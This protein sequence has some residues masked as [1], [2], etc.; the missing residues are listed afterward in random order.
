MTQH[1]PSAL[2]RLNESPGEH[3][4]LS[5]FAHVRT[6]FMSAPKKKKDHSLSRRYIHRSKDYEVRDIMIQCS[7]CPCFMNTSLYVET[8]RMTENQDAE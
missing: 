8:P 3:W 1:W 6:G 7:L 2:Q 5:G 4:R